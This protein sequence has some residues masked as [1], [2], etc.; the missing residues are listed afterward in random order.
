MRLGK[1]WQ[2]QGEDE[3]QWGWRPGRHYGSVEW[4]RTEMRA[5][6]VAQ[7]GVQAGAS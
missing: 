1:T 6:L 7:Q 4:E 2:E 5:A 3:A